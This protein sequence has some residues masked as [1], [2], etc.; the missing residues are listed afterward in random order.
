[1]RQKQLVATKY[2]LKTFL[3]S[4][5]QL[6]PSIMLSISIDKNL[7]LLVWF[8]LKYKKIEQHNATTIPCERT[9]RLAKIIITN[10]RIVK[11][12]KQLSK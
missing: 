6:R 4:K 10:F 8:V 7:D 9:Q 2:L 5:K 1:M 12:S 11:N 3:G